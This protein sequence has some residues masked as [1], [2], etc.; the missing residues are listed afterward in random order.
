MIP[1]CP[2]CAGELKGKVALPPIP[3]RQQRLYDMVVAS[4]RDGIPSN[5]LIRAMYEDGESMTPAGMTVLRVQI[6]LLNKQL[7]MLGKRIKGFRG[8][9]YRLVDYSHKVARETPATS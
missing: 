9:G 5:Q 8:S 6:H 1:R 3:P 4:G 7:A 2:Y